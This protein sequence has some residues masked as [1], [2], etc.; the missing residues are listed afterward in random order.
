MASVGGILFEGKNRQ[1]GRQ[2]I[3]PQIIRD[4]VAA[5]CR[6]YLLGSAA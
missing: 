4:T 3:S 1:I 6:N 5:A 2:S